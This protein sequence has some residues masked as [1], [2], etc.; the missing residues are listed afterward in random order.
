MKIPLLNEETG[1]VHLQ[2]ENLLYHQDFVN[3][4]QSLD[5]T[6]QMKEQNSI[7]MNVLYFLQKKKVQFLP[8]PHE[9]VSK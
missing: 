9:I 4:W 6:I 7:I 8:Y 5:I 2:M 3:F 1:S